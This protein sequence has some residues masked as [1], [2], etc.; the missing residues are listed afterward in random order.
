MT[1]E[2]AWLI[3]S[4]AREAW[5]VAT[6]DCL[7]AKLPMELLDNILEA[8]MALKKVSWR[9]SRPRDRSESSW[10]ELSLE[11]GMQDCFEWPSGLE[12]E[13]WQLLT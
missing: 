6:I 2:P 1:D 13:T 12:P 5:I 11:R 10:P 8:G 7:K 4:R 3:R 9:P